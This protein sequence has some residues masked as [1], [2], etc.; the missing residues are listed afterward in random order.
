MEAC[1][2]PRKLPEHPHVSAKLRSTRPGRPGAVT[3]RVRPLAVRNLL[4][5]TEQLFECEQG[6]SY[7][8]R[9]LNLACARGLG[10]EQHLRLSQ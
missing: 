3:A 5:I 8:L 7:L 2:A 4:G 9:L 10:A 6:L 1:A